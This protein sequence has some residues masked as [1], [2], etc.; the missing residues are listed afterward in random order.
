MYELL[1]IRQL[2]LAH[3]VMAQ[4]RLALEGFRELM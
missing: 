1:A 4:H 3:K 2:R